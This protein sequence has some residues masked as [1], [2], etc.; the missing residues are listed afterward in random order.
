MSLLVQMSHNTNYYTTYNVQKHHHLYDLHLY[1]ALLF[2][3]RS[4]LDR[5]CPGYSSLFYSNLEHSVSEGENFTLKFLCFVCFTFQTSILYD[6]RSKNL[7]TFHNYIKV[8][9]DFIMYYQS[10]KF[11][12]KRCQ[13]WLLS[14]LFGSDKKLSVTGR[15]LVFT[16]KK[17][18]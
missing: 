3:T 13:P 1:T 8:M 11:M 15:I 12:P 4:D 17:M 14:I 6:K 2:V 9:H 10:L 16:Y 7:G 18:F 5:V